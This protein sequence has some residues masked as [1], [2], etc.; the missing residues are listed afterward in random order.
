V[1]P[2][3]Q[4]DAAI[5]ATRA[6]LVLLEQLRHDPAPTRADL[7]WMAVGLVLILCLGVLRAVLFGAAA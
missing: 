1:T 2:D 3:E 5:R 4:L 6:R 7:G